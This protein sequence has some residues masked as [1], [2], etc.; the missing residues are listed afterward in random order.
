MAPLPP[1]RYEFTGTLTGPDGNPVPFTGALIPARRRP[2]SPYWPWFPC[3]P[4]RISRVLR[5]KAKRG[6]AA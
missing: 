5:R 2:W 6:P 3:A 1:G 4:A